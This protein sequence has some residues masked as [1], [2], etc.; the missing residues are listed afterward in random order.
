MNA[1]AG[2]EGFAEGLD[3]HE[4][5]MRTVGDAVKRPHCGP[6]RRLSGLEVPDN[7]ARVQIDLTR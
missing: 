7:A 6:A 4:N 2:R 3:L 5:R 1:P